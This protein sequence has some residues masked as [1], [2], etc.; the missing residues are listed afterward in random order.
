[1]PKPDDLPP[2][3]PPSQKTLDETLRPEAAQAADDAEKILRDKLPDPV[4]YCVNHDFVG[5]WKKDE[6]VGAKQVRDHLQG[7]YHRLPD[8]QVDEALARLVGLNAL[9]PFYE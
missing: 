5:P 9:V 1:M 6:R 8:G 3:A 2:F 7:Q 4:G